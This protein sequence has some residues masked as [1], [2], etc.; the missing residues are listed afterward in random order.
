MNQSSTRIRRAGRS[1]FTLVE[2]LLVMVIIAILAGIVVPKLLGRREQAN[3]TRAIADIAAIKSAITTF[4]VDNGRLP[5]QS[6]GLNALV[7]NP[8]G[9]AEWKS[10]LESVPVDPW[11][12][13]YV[14]HNPGA[15]GQEF[16]LYC[17]GPSG[18]DGNADNI[19]GK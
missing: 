10:L 5:T 15:N 4:E 18:Q 7:T 17:T 2:L 1:A 9:L 19:T 6:E 13:P 12:R 3:K 11:Q 8:G 14:Y 16:D